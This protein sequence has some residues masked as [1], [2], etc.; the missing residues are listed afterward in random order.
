M[1]LLQQ[2][3]GGNAAAAVLAF[4]NEL[5]FFRQRLSFTLCAI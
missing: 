2:N 5:N 1:T 4:A 3:I